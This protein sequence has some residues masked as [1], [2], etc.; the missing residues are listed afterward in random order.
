MEKIIDIIESI[1]HEKGLDI[2]EV[3]NTVTMALVKTAKKVYGNQYEYGAEIDATT[4]SLKLYQKVIVVTPDDERLLEGNE[5]FIAI[6]EAKE[7][8]PDIEIG[9]ELTYALPLDNLG[10]TAAATQAGLQP[11]SAST[12]I[13]LGPAIIS[14]PTLPNTFRLAVAT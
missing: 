11:P 4:K 10:R 1:A 8:D 3:R 14:M 2:T 9:D 5:N 6:K 13:S 7:V 12:R